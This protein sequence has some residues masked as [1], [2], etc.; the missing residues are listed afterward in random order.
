MYSKEKDTLIDAV[1]NIAPDIMDRI[2]EAL[3][4]EIND[5]QE[6][7]DAEIYNERSFEHKRWIIPAVTSTFALTAICI[8]LVIFIFKPKESND[9]I[10]FIDVNPS[11][12]MHINDENNVVELYGANEDGDNIISGIDKGGDWQVTMT[13]ILSK[14]NDEG[15]FYNKDNDVLVSYVQSGRIGNVDK[16]MVRSAISDF[17]NKSGVEL[18][19]IYQLL[20]VN[21][22]EY[23]KDGLGDY[24]VGR[25]YFINSI[26]KNYGIDEEELTGKDIN[27]IVECL[28]SK[29]INISDEK[30]SKCKEYH[31][32][33]SEKIDKKHIS[34]PTPS[35]SPQVISTTKP[36]SSAVTNNSAN[37]TIE[38]SEK[39]NDKQKIKVTVTDAPKKSEVKLCT[40]HPSVQKNKNNKE[41][42]TPKDKNS[43]I[44]HD[45]TD[46]Y[47][48]DI[49]PSTEEENNDNDNHN[50]YDGNEQSDE[51]NKQSDKKHNDKYYVNKNSSSHINIDAIPS[52]VPVQVPTEK[53]DII[54]QPEQTYEPNSNNAAAQTTKAPLTY[55]ESDK[56]NEK[57]KGKTESAK[58]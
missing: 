4:H 51:S 19:I 9:G 43:S 25:K 7:F 36:E 33:K 55:K 56:N 44:I 30:N 32:D 49:S 17:T 57:N 47:D 34:T 35:E 8:L 29:N 54:A 18:T 24:S 45:N 53:P 21:T 41:Y 38:D 15:Y 2:S 1:D 13:Q 3:V 12:E 26:K 6:L 37:S 48:K 10:I 23:Y 31:V 27:G 5:E 11:I 52:A 14:I 28:N 20:D 40:E 58:G 42:D 16:D 50:I 46:C 39:Y 22:L